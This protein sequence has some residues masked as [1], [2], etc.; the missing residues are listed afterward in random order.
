MNPYHESLTKELINHF[1]KSVKHIN[2]FKKAKVFIDYVFAMLSNDPKAIRY[3][4]Q[5]SKD[6]KRYPKEL[7]L[8]YLKVCCEWLTSMIQQRA[9]S[10]KRITKMLLKN[11]FCTGVG[12]HN[13][14]ELKPSR[15]GKEFRRSFASTAIRIN[16]L[17]K[18]ILRSNRPT[19]LSHS[20]RD[21]RVA[22]GISQN[23][24]A[25]HGHFFNGPTKPIA[26]PKK[27]TPKF[28]S[29]W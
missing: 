25:T 18:K 1:P 13:P 11:F 28:K 20:K 23:S 6:A 19:H 7:R 14:I 8:E 15:I 24:T 16:E 22:V 17:L 3:I 5:F 10:P 9:D 29:W 2:P 12:L 27:P 4:G 26:I 21:N